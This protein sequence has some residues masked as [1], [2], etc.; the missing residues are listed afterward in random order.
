MNLYASG[1]LDTPLGF[2]SALVVGL[3]FGFWLER[4]GFGSSRRLASF[5]YLRD[6]AVL[7][8]MFSA[9]VTAALGLWI[10]DAF[11]WIDATALYRMETHYGAAALGG[12]LFGVGFVVGGWC[13]GTAWV[14]LASL[15]VDALVFLAGAV[16][17][18]GAY[19]ALWPALAP[20]QDVGARGV[21]TLPETVGL[22]TGTLTLLVAIVAVSVFV[23]THVFE[24]RTAPKDLRP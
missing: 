5:F 9:L 3:F 21:C 8:V 20:I 22:S 19:A 14:G 16:L 24:R 6:F 13:P 10:G 4:A 2:A 17:G 12:A 1:L 15:R 18:S 11:G 23:L 7:R